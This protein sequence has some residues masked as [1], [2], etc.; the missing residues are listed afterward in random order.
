MACKTRRNFRTK[1]L[2]RKKDNMF[3][4]LISSA[5]IADEQE[6]NMYLLTKHTP[7]SLRG[8]RDTC[9][10]SRPFKVQAEKK[11]LL[12]EIKPI[13]TTRSSH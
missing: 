2:R 8:V 9:E 11:I 3:L 13:R 10:K 4:E 12:L 5:A 7:R 6:K 1:H